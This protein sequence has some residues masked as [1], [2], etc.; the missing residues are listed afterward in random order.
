MENVMVNVVS[1]RVHGLAQ[2]VGQILGRQR[3]GQRLDENE[4]KRVW[5]AVV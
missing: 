2:A 4:E 1:R 5:G 3:G